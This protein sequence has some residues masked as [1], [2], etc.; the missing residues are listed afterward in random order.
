DS[1]VLYRG[2]RAPSL[3][4]GAFGVQPT[5]SASALPSITAPS[6]SPSAGSS[7]SVGP[8]VASPTT[9]PVPLDRVILLEN[10]SAPVPG[11]Y[12]FAVDPSSYEKASGFGSRP[13]GPT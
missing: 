12:T 4:G 5:P 13:G 7:P 2:Y 11:E 3:H 1:I 8:A 10:H 9:G 6:A